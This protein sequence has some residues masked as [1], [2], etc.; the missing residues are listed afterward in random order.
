MSF[1]DCVNTAVEGGEVSKD[2]AEWL[3]RRFAQFQRQYA[4]KGAMA[5]A[6]AKRALAKLLAAETAHQRRKA[7]LV[8]KTVKRIDNDLR[9][10]RNARGEH[11]Y[12]EGARFL[13]EHYGE[14]AFESVVGRTNA[15]VG[16]A[17]ARMASL[18]DHFRR[19]WILG[20]KGR[21]NAAQLDNVAREAFGEATGDVAAKEFARVW[22]DTHE[23]LRQ[24]FNAAGGAIG[25]LERW[26]LP[27]AHDAQA[28]RNAGREQW[29]ADI[30]PALDVGRM[31]HPLTGDP[32]DPA[33]LSGILD[34]L[35][36]NIVT[37]GWNDRQP[38]MLAFGRGALANQ[39]A[40]H[41][42]L[43]F[44][45]ADAWLKYQRDYGRNGDVFGAMMGHINMMARDIAAMEILGPNPNG[46][47]EWVKQAVTKQAQ[48]H[49]AGQKSFFAGKPNNALGNASSTLH[50]LDAVW[51]SIRGTSQAPVNSR[52]AAF[53]SGA[54]NL[55]S[56]STMGSAFLSAFSDV[57]TSIIE[58][59]FAGIGGSAM[60]DIVNG[61][62][63]ATEREAVDA[64]LI[65]DSARH[66]FHAQ[67]RYSGTL[68]GPGWTSFIADRVLAYSGLTAW[69]QAAKHG[70]GIA[71]MREA[72]NQV[73]KRFDELPEAFRNTFARHGI[74][75]TDWERMRSVPVYTTPGGMKLLR[76]TEIDRG[77][78]TPFAEKY[79]SMIHKETAFAVPEGG[80]RARVALT[81]QTRPGTF[82]GEVLRS[83]AQFKS[84]GAVFAILHGLRIHRML[85]GGQVGKGAAYAA[86]LLISTTLFGALSLQLKQIAGGRDPRNM[87]DVPFWGAALLQGGG[88]GLFG[89]FLFS[90]INRFGGGFAQTL[91]GPVV[92]RANDLWDLTAGNLVELATD[93]SEGKK[94]NTHF[95]RELIKFARGNIPG[96]NLW[97]IKLAWERTVMDQLQFLADP[98]AAKAF[99][100]QSQF[101]AKNF[102]QDYWWRPG[103]AAPDRGPALSAVARAR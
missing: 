43:I 9:N 29:K 78:G 83:F 71:F 15:I 100:R 89:D 17:H 88:L 25:K 57:G 50:S 60:L 45:N 14:A 67:A 41:R 69:T 16:M 32:V 21:W 81:G 96:S 10:H 40:E 70:F 93:L 18:L 99:R 48:L 68:D 56:A 58:R 27:Q 49:Q 3:K 82:L 55:I 84:F 46:M 90:N 2:N 87:K 86:S 5:D 62:R 76:P 13:L 59:R 47:I 37:E 74:T 54:R 53:F 11:D 51:A 85:V 102:G 52:I 79:L 98:E 34:D 72:A 65:L 22:E 33:E 4:A 63:G 19:G 75:P 20:D 44:K 1:N 73:A 77:P 39:R 12:A 80:H 23:L 91:G 42:F 64:G 6:E 24:R 61:F 38:S 26:G 101:W 35:W 103:A 66:V 97:Y 94:I 92:S 8:I 31:K 95:G 7:K 28:L 30:T 36:Q